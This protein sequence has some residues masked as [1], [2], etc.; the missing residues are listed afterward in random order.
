MD[1][2]WLI[3]IISVLGPILGSLIGIIKRPSAE[4]TYRLLAFAGGVM[5]SISFLQLIP[6]SIKFSSVMI[7]LA[8]FIIGSI[9]MYLVDTVVPHI[10]PELCSQEQ[11]C[12]LERTSTY[13]LLGLFLH[14]IPEGMAIAIGV[15]SNQ[16]LSLLIALAIAIQK[17]P[18][19][20]CTSASYFHCT[21]KR[22]RS[23]LISAA[24]ILPL[25]LGFFLSEYL[26][27]QMPGSLIGLII[28][29]TAGI[30]IYITADELVPTSC[31][32]LTGHSGIFA[33]I[34][35][36]ALVMLLGLL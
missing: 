23:F 35:G 4:M 10:H 13:L 36:V 8:G 7:C 29:A 33:F 14:N 16:K 9:I 32:K 28:G 18:E 20:I 31:S 5:I 17:I 6:Q 25:L 27:R 26:F 15:V 12:N 19:G 11:G 22:L 1:T 2:I 21:G 34:A 3:L 30:M 24:N